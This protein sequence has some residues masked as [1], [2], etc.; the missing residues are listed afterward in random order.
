M[1]R[2]IYLTAWQVKSA[3]LTLMIARLSLVKMVPPVS[4]VLTVTHA[5]VQLDSLGLSARKILTTASVICVRPAPAC[6][7]ILW[8]I[9]DAIARP[10][11]SNWLPL[12]CMLD[13]FEET[14]IECMSERVWKRWRVWSYLCKGGQNSRGRVREMPKDNGLWYNACCQ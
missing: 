10:V 11:S 9:I 7:V 12:L 3:R 8:T 4:M 13:G 6:A 5:N 2:G 1:C 14:E